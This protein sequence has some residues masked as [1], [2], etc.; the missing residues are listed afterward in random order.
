MLTDLLGIKWKIGTFGFGIAAI[1]LGVAC[2]MLS[3]QVDDLTKQLGI[4]RIDLAQARANSATL[5]AALSDQNADLER[6]AADSKQR[7][8]AANRALAEAQKRSKVAQQRV[9][10]LLDRPIK[11]STLEER[12]LEVDARVLESLK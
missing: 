7:L 12:V 9:T 3:G 4:V 5:E 6:F 2:F 10:L 11:G 1:A 8:D